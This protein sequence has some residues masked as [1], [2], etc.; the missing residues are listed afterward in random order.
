M[1]NVWV[2]IVMRRDYPQDR[3]VPTFVGIPAYQ[4]PRKPTIQ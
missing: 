1:D 3:L 4:S 2:E